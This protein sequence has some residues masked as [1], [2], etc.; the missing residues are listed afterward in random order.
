MRRI[1][2]ALSR[3]WGEESLLEELPEPPSLSEVRRSR[4]SQGIFACGFPRLA[5]ELSA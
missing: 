2:Y 3:G 1:W 5:P 4:E